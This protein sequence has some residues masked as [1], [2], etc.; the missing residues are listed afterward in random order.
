MPK[1]RTALIVPLSSVLV[2]ACVGLAQ[3]R[4]QEG[5]GGS[6]TAQI[7]GVWRGNS[8]CAVENSPC[9][10]EV[11]VYRISEPA[12]RPGWYS[13]AGGK[14]VDGKEVAMGTSD[15]KYEPETHALT[16]ES[17]AG[18]F[19]LT[20]NGNSMEGSLTLKDGTVYRRIHLHRSE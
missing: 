7:A 4:A 17:P 20:V 11:N 14:I 9:Q 18:R 1:P 8:V 15:W 16:N 10:N 2:S 19:L 3:I 5:M 12:G 13:I 6:P